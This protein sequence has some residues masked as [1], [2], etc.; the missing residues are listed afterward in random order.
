MSA[1]ADWEVSN[2]RLDPRVEIGTLLVS[3]HADGQQS[4]LTCCVWDVSLSGACLMVPP[5][6]DVPEFFELRIG[7]TTRKA[8]RVWRKGAK[9]GAEFVMPTQLR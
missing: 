8:R 6:A 5:T 3:I 7:G 2:R 9:I 1:L 4:E